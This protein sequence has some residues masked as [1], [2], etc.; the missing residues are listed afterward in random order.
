MEL[1]SLL[2]LALDVGEWSASRPG[3]FT[4]GNFLNRSLGGSQSPAGFFFAKDTSPCTNL[5][6][7]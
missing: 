3:R 4:L 2:A 1:R 5:N 7:Y 6:E